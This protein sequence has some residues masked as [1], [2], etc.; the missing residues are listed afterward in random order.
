MNRRCFLKAGAQATVL[1]AVASTHPATAVAASARTR[2][3]AS[4]VLASYTGED[5]RRRLQNIALAERSVRGCMRKHLITDYLAG[6]CVYNLGEYP[7]RK[8]WNP[9]KWDEQELDRLHAHGIRLIQVHEE[10]NDMLRRHGGDKYSPVNPAGFRRF[11]DMVHRRGMKVIVYISTGFFERTDPDFREEWARQKDLVEIYFYYARCS[12]ASPGWRAYLLPRLAK[13]LD[14]YEVDGFYNDT[15]YLSLANNP[16]PPASDEVPAFNERPGYDG[17]LTDLLALIFAEVKRRGGLFKL[18]IGG[19][20]RPQTDQKI[21]DYLWVG[22]GGRSGDKLREKTKDYPPYVAPCLDMSRA[23]IDNE[24][25]LYLHTIPYLQFPVLLG[26]RPFTGER[27]AIPGIPYPPE[28][29]CFWT[30][31]LRAIWKQYQANPKGPHSYGWWDSCPG[32]PEA[33]PAHARWL[34]QYLP[35]VEEGTWAWLEVSDSDLFTQPLPQDVVAS[36]FANREFHIVLAN[37][38]RSAAA[39]T[40]KDA[41][42]AAGSADTAPARNWNLAG[43]TLQIMRRAATPS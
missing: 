3:A 31:H 38:G 9:D 13:I 20:M 18:H 29:K 23:R 8:P 6:H 30:R 25:E 28:E 10:W 43:R 7:C 37:Y 33:R 16:R 32:R 19:A 5:H 12:P 41:F 14:S 34:K 35:L 26:G 11:V 15:G 4:P 22:E 42:V 36:V 17:A 40:T 21:Y 1:G 27:A 2:T 39:V 24:D